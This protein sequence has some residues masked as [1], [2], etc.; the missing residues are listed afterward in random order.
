MPAVAFRY[1]VGQAGGPPAAA[2]GVAA[3][4]D[5]PADA[6]ADDTADALGVDAP[7]VGAADVADADVADADVAAVDGPGAC[8]EELD[9]EGEGEHPATRTTRAAVPIAAHPPSVLPP[10]VLPRS[11]I[12][13][14][15]VILA[16]PPC[17]P[18]YTALVY[19]RCTTTY[20]AVAAAV[21]GQQPSDYVGLPTGMR[22]P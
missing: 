4:E 15:N 9:D 22:D 5:A 16:T 7:T 19:N 3:P 10:S 17:G 18:S 1:R 21:V 20:D 12:L 13:C 6:P 14:R 8:A 2:P 11:V